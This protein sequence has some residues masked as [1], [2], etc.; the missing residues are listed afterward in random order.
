MNAKRPNP[1]ERVVTWLAAHAAFPSTRLAAKAETLLCVGAL[2][3]AQE[4]AEAERFLVESR[5]GAKDAALRAHALRRAQV[6]YKCDNS[7]KV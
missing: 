2:A 4:A 6:H 3:E 1:L 7:A 5:D